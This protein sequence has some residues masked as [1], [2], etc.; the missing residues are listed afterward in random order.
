LEDRVCPCRYE[1]AE[2]YWLSWVSG[3]AIK[4]LQLDLC[5]I[6]NYSRVPD[7]WYCSNVNGSNEVSVIKLWFQDLRIRFVYSV[8]AFF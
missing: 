3:L 8:I 4:I 1:S 2:H 7:D 5:S 6:N